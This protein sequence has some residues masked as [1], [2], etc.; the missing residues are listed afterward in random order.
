MRVVGSIEALLLCDV[1][2]R[3]AQTGKWTLHG[4]F[5]AVWAAAYPA[6]HQT[7]DVYFRVRI[8]G[9]PRLDVVCRDPAGAV[10][11]VTAVAP[12]PAP[13]GL[14]EGAVRVLGLEL[15]AP[16]EYRFELQV[17]GAG[18]GSTGL[19]VGRLPRPNDT[20]H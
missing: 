6:T 18:V 19:I 3:D 1:A 15:A 16:G 9:A 20:R 8:T 5:D 10:V 12:P 4:V 2:Q 13:R 11:F 14:V 7:L 17:D